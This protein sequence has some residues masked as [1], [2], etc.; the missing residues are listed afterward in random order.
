VRNPRALTTLAG[1]AG[2]ALALTLLQIP[3]N[4][5]PSIATPAASAAVQKQEQPV[6]GGSASAFLVDGTEIAYDIDVR[7]VMVERTS[8]NKAFSYMTRDFNGKPAR[9]DKCKPI[10]YMVNTRGMPK[11][12][13]QAIP[14][15]IRK[16]SQASGLKFRKGKNTRVIPYSKPGWE[17]SLW[18]RGGGV[19]VIAAGTPRQVPVFAGVGVAGFGGNFWQGNPKGFEVKVG[20]VVVNSTAK[21]N[22]GFSGGDSSNSY[23]QLLLHELGHVMNLGHTTNEKQVMHPGMLHVMPKDYAGGDRAG[24]RGMRSLPCF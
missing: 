17:S 15:A 4:T 3:T 2:V 11:E 12:I 14:E 5:Q 8:R 18:N 23:G 7:G 1:A 24:F 6:R 16:V 10:T 19:I 22:P 20:G 9:W 21:L 13:R